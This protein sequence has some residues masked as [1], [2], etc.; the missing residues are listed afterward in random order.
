MTFL[1]D[2][3]F[4]FWKA[5][6]WINPRGH[7]YFRLD[8]IL[9]KGFSKP[10]GGVSFTKIVRGCACRTSKIWLS[11]YQFFAEFP[12][13]QYTIFER[14]AHN[15]TKLGAF[16]NIL[17]QIH[18]IYVI[19]VPSSLMKPPIAIPNFAKKRPKRQVH[20]R[21]PPGSK[22]TLNTYFSGMKIDPK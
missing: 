12:T 1:K 6:F 5:I 10:R 13:H 7:L 3:F 8:I 16:Y 14:K 9:V 15:L 22:H 21:K 17:P 19:W 2:F 4:F 11:L 20:I 18:P